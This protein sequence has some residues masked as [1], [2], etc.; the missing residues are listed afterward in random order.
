MNNISVNDIT[1]LFDRQIAGWKVAADNYAALETVITKT[2]DV[3]GMTWNVQFNP[4]R[5]VST[6]ARVSDGKVD[7]PCFLCRDNRPEQQMEL[8]WKRY[9]ILVNPYPIFPRHFTVVSGDHEP[10]LLGD[11]LSDMI[12]LAGSLPGYVVFYNGAR[13]GASAPDHMHFQIG[14][15]DFLPLDRNIENS[16]K[17]IRANCNGAILTVADCG[18]MK[19][20]VIDGKRADDIETLYRFQALPIAPGESEPR[21]NIMCYMRDDGK[22]RL[23]IIPRTAHRPQCYNRGEDS[24]LVSPGAVD[25][26]GVAITVRPED[27]GRLDADMLREILSDVGYVDDI[28]ISQPVVNVGIMSSDRISI[29]EVSRDSGE[30]VKRH[31]FTVDKGVMMCDGS[32]V[33]CDRMILEPCGGDSVFE[34]S[35]VTIGVGFHWQRLERQRFAGR[36]RL[37][38]SAGKIVVINE[39]AVEEYLKSVISSEMS[40]TSSLELLKAHAVISRSWLMAQIINRNIS[41]DRI[42]ENIP[43][44]DVDGDEIIKWYDREE[45]QLFDVCADDHCQRYQGV[46]RQ[47]S[48]LVDEAVAATS[49]EVITSDDEL[50]DARFSKCCGGVFEQFENCWDNTPKSYLAARRDCRCESDYPDLTDETE[51]RKWILSRP[52]SFCNTSDSAILGQVLNNYDR[53][54]VDFYRWRVEYDSVV[55]A[56][57]IAKR[58]GI[59][60]GEIIDII[61]VERGTSGRIIKLRIVG[62]RRT[63]TVGKELE[64]RRWLS[65]SHLYSSA[66]VMDKIVDDGKTT[67]VL[68]GAGWGHGVGLCQIGAAVM[69]E[70]GYDYREILRHYYKGVVI[71]KMY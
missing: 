37:M 44:A 3:D 18:F 9:S 64:I 66:F 60:F 4:A 32:P 38:L 53:E 12:N 46:T 7:R 43:V 1:D 50:C 16:R 22:I 48:P 39:V 26:S 67:F 2:V 58:S 29:A 11:R 25:V 71:T 23:V 59:D 33:G 49:G 19:M 63:V 30:Y 34:L 65:E 54:T 35:D 69:G 20:I 31:V 5:A 42:V 61:P 62:T 70:L 14:N 56:Q 55:L 47:T 24:L 28:A 17:G 15:L 40:A 13:C 41:G 52:E 36:M 57:L 45:H 68:N 8:K 21:M 6:L 51:A 27:F 10:Q